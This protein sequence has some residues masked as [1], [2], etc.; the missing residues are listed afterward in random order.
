MTNHFKIFATMADYEAYIAGEHA[1]PLVA[2]IS[3]TGKCVLPEG[4]GG[5]GNQL[6][7]SI[8]IDDFT[9][10]SINMVTGYITEAYI[11]DGVT[12]IEGDAFN[13]CDLLA[14]VRIPSSVTTIGGYAFGSCHSLTSVTI[15]EGVTAIGD[16]AFAYCTSL[17]SLTVR[18][19]T[20][21]TLG[22]YALEDVP[23]TVNIYVPAA[24]VDAYK[25]ADRWKGRASRIKAIPE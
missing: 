8:G 19:T 22:S 14:S 2:Y 1:T 6:L 20:P 18:A 5:G 24:S 12:T 25:A 17:T 4:S 7:K 3:A 11:P 15:P 13:G 21:P 23:S 16:Y 9:E 10:T